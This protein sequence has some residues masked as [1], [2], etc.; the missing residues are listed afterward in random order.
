MYDSPRRSGS[1][2]TVMVIVLGIVACLCVCVAALGGGAAYLAVTTNNIVTQISTQ[3]QP[4][5]TEIFQPPTATRRPATATAVPQVVLTPVPTPVAGA[6]DTLQT[7]ENEAIPPS[8]LRELAMRLKGTGPIPEVVASAPANYK[9][10][11]ELKFNASNEDTNATFQVQAKLIYETA[12]AYFFAQDGVRVDTQAVKALV[13]TFQ[14][15]IYPTDRSFFGSEWT[16]GV[17]DDPHLTILYVGG[18]GSS[19]AGYFSSADEYSHLAHPYSN[20]KEMFY[21]N[22]DNQNPG[23]PYLLG[24]LAHE[25]QHMI[26]WAHDRNEETWMNE[27]SS[28]LAEFLNHYDIGGFDAAYTSN[29]DLQLDGWSQDPATDPNVSAHYGAGFLFMA[30]FLDRFGNAATQALV[31]NPD[32]G[33]RAVDSTLASLHITDKAT[34]KALTSVDLFADWTIANYLGDASVGDGRYAYH[35]YPQAP[36]VDSPTDTYATC[37]TQ[38]SATG[39]QFGAV[40]FEIDCAGQH[41]ISFTGSQQ[42]QVIPTKP[43]SGRYAFWGHRNDESDTRMTR[44]FDLTGLTKATLNYRAWWE[45]EKDYDFTYLE[46]STDGGS[47][48]TILKTPSGTAGNTTGNNLGWGYTGRSGGGD[49]G[50]WVNESVDLSAY[51]GKK[52]QLRFEYVTDAAVNWPGFMVDDISIP[53]LKYSTD[54]EAD[55][56]GWKGEGFVRMDNVLPQKFMVQVIAQGDQT[57]VQRVILDKNNQG[58]LDVNLATGQK[59]V[60]VV[61]GITPFTTEVSSFQFAIK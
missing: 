5:L 6:S 32:N 12:N 3:V 16:P 51:A 2:V 21:V 31:A 10:G 44:E 30:Y 11:Q 40:Y 1:P 55:A 24:V 36:K 53:E 7:L 49:A 59:A 61:S 34:G 43:Y 29:P 15:K 8:D 45:L 39:H 35:N 37:P 47:T 56:G 26:H 60:L 19:I 22:A 18:I 48:W 20:E 33:M 27:G 23:D 52:T 4:Q 50:Q 9:V 42:V 28:V 17:D 25:F 41:T 46:A 13:D 58:S 14:N 54:F 57:T 38:A